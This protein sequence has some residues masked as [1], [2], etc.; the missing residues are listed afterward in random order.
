MSRESKTRR[1]RKTLGI[2]LN[3]LVLFLFN[4]LL[5]A[6]YLGALSVPGIGQEPSL[7]FVECGSIMF[8]L[9]TFRSLIW[10]IILRYHTQQTPKCF[11]YLINSMYIASMISV[12]ICLIL[13]LLARNLIIKT[14]L[15]H[16][17]E[18]M[19]IANII[20]SVIAMIWTLFVFALL[21]RPLRI[22]RF[23][24]NAYDVSSKTIM[25]KTAAFLSL[26]IFVL[27]VVICTLN[28]LRFTL[29]IPSNWN[30]IVVDLI[31][32]SF[33]CMVA[34]LV[35]V[36]WML[37]DFKINMC[38]AM[39]PHSLCVH[40]LGDICCGHRDTKG[41]TETQSAANNSFLAPHVHRQTVT[42]INA[43]ARNQDN[44]QLKS[45]TSFAVP[46]LLSDSF[47]FN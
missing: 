33:L 18:L 30:F 46:T 13:W 2:L 19:M 23:I 31:W 22:L 27:M 8:A 38:C 11:V 45:L 26:C 32:H 17:E 3:I 12:S 5:F 24:G 37:I 10:S 44:D 39:Q 21:Q 40:V 43:M 16:P 34:A 4:S 15:F 47:K 7:I 20:F 14:N 41:E 6:A 36:V 1:L 35:L 28:A 29:W 25:L 9:Y 42:S